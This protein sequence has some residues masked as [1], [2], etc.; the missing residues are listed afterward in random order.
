[1]SR[2]QIA[3]VAL[4]ALLFAA[5]WWNQDRGLKAVANQTHSSL[6]ALKQDIEIRQKRS[7]EYLKENPRGI[8]SKRNGEVIIPAALIQQG[9]DD[10][11]SA[12]D[13]LSGLSC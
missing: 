1:M 12:L 6:C 5:L 3:Y 4:V 7:V 11:K 8:V 13:A 2:R 9:I 10:R